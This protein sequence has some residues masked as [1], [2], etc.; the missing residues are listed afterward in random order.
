MRYL[1]AAAA[2]R[3]LGIGDKTI[4]RWL[5]AGRFPSAIMKANG[6]YAIPEQEVESLRQYR[7]KYVHTQETSHNQSADIRAIAEKVAA[8]EKEVAEL[9][10]EQ[11][12]AHQS[13]SSPSLSPV[14]RDNSIQKEVAQNRSTTKKRAYTKKT[15]VRL[16][17]GCVLATE[18]GI[19]HGIKRET[20]RDHMN[21]GLGPG[22][23][24]G[25][26]VPEDGS[27]QIKDWV[28]SEERNKRVRQDGTVEKERYLTADQ[29]AAALAFWRRHHVGFSQCER[30]N[31]PCHL[32]VSGETL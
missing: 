16:P 10:K 15:D 31:C 7:M 26:N 9:R 4:R 6:E 32:T 21:N 28:R 3:V 12:L 19:Q 2:A 5:K 27:V 25:P 8:L 30:D 22:L 13:L 17:E 24:H 18:F 23:I 11:S 29:Q 20:F 1:N 14:P